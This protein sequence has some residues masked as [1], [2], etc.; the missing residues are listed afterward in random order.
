MPA[1]GMVADSAKAVFCAKVLSSSVRQRTDFR[2][3]LPDDMTT[4]PEADLLEM[5]DALCDLGPSSAEEAD[6][7][8]A[9]YLGQAAVVSLIADR[10]SEMRRQAPR[11]SSLV[12]FADLNVRI[13]RLRS[14][15]VRKRLALVLEGL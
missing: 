14:L 15:R 13:K 6:A 3:S 7:L 12:A 8:N 9:L 10:L 2:R 11:I 5:A 4:W 1:K